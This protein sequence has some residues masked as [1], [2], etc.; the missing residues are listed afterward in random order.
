M[1]F[2]YVASD[3]TGRIIE[4]NIEALNSY[5][6]LTLLAKKGLRPISI[7]VVRNIDVNFKKF[8][9][10]S[11]TIEDKI[12]LTKY[13]SLM[14]RAGT[15]LF[16]AI[17]IL[18]QDFEKPV[19]KALLIEIGNTLE[20]GQPF[21]LTFSRYPRYF[22]SVFVSL[23]K[24]GEVSGNLEEVFLNLSNSLQKDQE[25]YGRV[26]SAFVYPIILMSV[27]ALILLLLVSFALP[28]VADVFLK[29]GFKV[30]T[31]SKIVF[32]IG[33]F[34]NDYKMI[35]FPAL[36]VSAFILYYFFAKTV[37]GRQIVSRFI[38]KTP[39]INKVMKEMALQR[40]AS[41][42]A[43]LMKAGLP[44]L[45]SLEITADAVGS[46]ELRQALLRISREG[47]AKGL[48]I[49]EA[50]RKEPYFPMTITN[51]IA[52]SEKAGHTEDILNTLADF[53]AT[54]IDGRVKNLVAFLEPILLLG[55]GVIIGTIALAVIVP[56]YQLVGG[57]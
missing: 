14:L 15:D 49:G 33:L 38:N 34:M 8:F 54:E 50:F 19:L 28:K 17:T 9:G 32:T 25:L 44:I 20:K 27:S 3:P 42:L 30:P 22:S 31:F 2:H 52:V 12:F 16:R 36:F 24:A 35:I 1:K 23:I 5:D 55:I 10:Q 51:L 18:I 11:V 4:D 46:E 37:P 47:V 7:K 13:L 40:F 26:K 53:Y 41:T 43:S 29:S 45:D 57:M 21:Y 56:V 48:T 6:V 39:L